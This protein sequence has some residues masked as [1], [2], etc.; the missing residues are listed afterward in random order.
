LGKSMV[1]DRQE[2]R[3]EIYWLAPISAANTGGGHRNRARQRQGDAVARAG[4]RK[5]TRRAREVR[6]VG[7]TEPPGRVRPGRPAPGRWSE[8]GFLTNFK[9]QKLNRK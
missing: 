6:P 4:K 7:L 3:R 5:R 1:A 9:K 8:R 2:H